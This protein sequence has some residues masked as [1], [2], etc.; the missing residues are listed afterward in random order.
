MSARFPERSVRNMT[1]TRRGPYLR[2]RTSQLMKLS[3]T[4]GLSVQTNTSKSS[5]LGIVGS[6]SAKFSE[7]TRLRTLGVM[8]RLIQRYAPRCI[9]S[10]GCHLGGVDQ[11]A[12]DAG[13]DHGLQVVEHLPARRVWSGGYRERN[14]RIAQDSDRVVCI[15]VKEFPQSYRGMRFPYCYHCK[16]D[17]HIKSGGCWTAHYASK[18]GKPACIIVVSEYEPYVSYFPIKP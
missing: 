10:G 1:T 15:S 16:T 12:A 9:V 6:E 8:A 14:I 7:T 5:T 17:S 11:W 18:L 13:R 4:V 3:T 2:F